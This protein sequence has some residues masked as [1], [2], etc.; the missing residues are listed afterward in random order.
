MTELGDLFQAMDSVGSCDRQ[1]PACSQQPSRRGRRRGRDRS[2][3]PMTWLE[4]GE[5]VT[6]MFKLHLS[7]RDPDGLARTAALARTLLAR[8]PDGISARPAGNDL[9]E[10]L[11]LRF[12]RLSADRMTAAPGFRPQATSSAGRSRSPRRL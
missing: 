4:I 6:S 7:A 12:T 2:I 8:A 9:L 3:E 10:S 5:L 11:V 1:L